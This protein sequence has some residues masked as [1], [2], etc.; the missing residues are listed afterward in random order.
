MD[1]KITFQDNLIN[2]ENLVIIVIYLEKMITLV[3]KNKICKLL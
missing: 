3:V 2:K 1:R